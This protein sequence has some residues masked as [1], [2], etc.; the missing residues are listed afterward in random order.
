M[1]GAFWKGFLF[2]CQRQREHPVSTLAVV[3]P[4]A[5]PRSLLHQSTKWMCLLTSV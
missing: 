4:K 1:F 3:S 5:M 2:A